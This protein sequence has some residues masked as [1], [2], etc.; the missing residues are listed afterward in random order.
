[1]EVFVEEPLA[2][3]GSAKKR[4][5]SCVTCTRVYIQDT[6]FDLRFVLKQDIASTKDFSEN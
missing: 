3:P 4:R 6:C 1:M 5:T 2:S